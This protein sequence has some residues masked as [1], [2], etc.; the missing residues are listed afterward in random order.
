MIFPRDE[1]IY[2]RKYKEFNAGDLK[3]IR[4][5]KKK[6]AWK[7]S[8]LLSMNSTNSSNDAQANRYDFD[9]MINWVIKAFEEN[10]N[11]F[12][13]TRNVIYTYWLMNTRIPVVHKIALVELLISYWDKPNVFVVGDDDQSI[14]RFQGANVENMLA[15][16]T[17][18]KRPAH[19]DLP[20]IIVQPNQY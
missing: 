12:A 17:V 10:K 11:L 9:D 4:L 18:I 8:V 5:K 20:I 1:F 7:N 3:K 15:L 19:S 2:K 14:Y 6:N 16:P 13:I